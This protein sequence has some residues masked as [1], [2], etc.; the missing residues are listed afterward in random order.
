MELDDF[1][2]TIAFEEDVGL[3]VVLF[4]DFSVGQFCFDV[5]KIAGN[6][7]VLA[8]ADLNVHVAEIGGLHFVAGSDVFGPLLLV[9]SEVGA[10]FGEPLGEVRGI[11]RKIGGQIVGGV[12]G[13]DLCFQVANLLF[14]GG[15]L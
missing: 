15:W 1:P 10:A 6:G 11:R 7:C 5:E 2:C 14:D 3:L 12:T 13:V 8:R 4:R 9:G